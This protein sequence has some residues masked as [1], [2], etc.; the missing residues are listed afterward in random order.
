MGVHNASGVE[1]AL[2]IAVDLGASSG[3]VILGGLAPGELLLQETGRFTH[4]MRKRAGHLRWDLA[5]IVREVKA[6][7]AEAASLARRMNRPIVSIGVDTFGVD[8]AF[9]DKDGAVIDD[10]I[11]YRDSRTA[12]TMAKVFSLVPSQELYGR[13]GIQMMVFNTIFQLYQHLKDGIPENANRLLLMADLINHALCGKVA[14]EYSNATTTQLVD[15]HRRDWDT[16]LIEKIGLPL[17]LFPPI[18]PSG[19]DLG[20]VL[21]ALAE[22]LHLPSDVRVVAPATHDTGSAI[23][24]APLQPGWAYISSGTWSLIGIERTSP[25]I[26]PE[27]AMENFTNEGGAYGTI[28]FLKNCMGLWLFEACKVKWEQEGL[29]VDYGA[30][31]PQVAALTES[32]GLIFPDDPRLFNPDDM[33][34]AIAEQ[35]RETGQT[36]LND[37]VAITKV[38]LDSLALRYARIVQ[39]IEQLTG[40][41]ISGIQVVGG[42]AQNEYLSRATADATGKQVVCGPIEATATGNILVQAI[43]AGR[44][45][46]LATARQHVNANTAIQSYAPGNPERWEMLRQRYAQLESRFVR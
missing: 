37:P 39:T 10:P 24:G 8:Y 28:R 17:K 11:S 5:R 15:S 3:R 23:A 43:A 21:P 33:V 22:E 46:D 34:A 42:G 38:I 41:T 18:V 30:F 27:V 4:P 44:F 40:D 36:P 13:T 20:P 6:G 25:L 9:L 35:M 2:Y 31:L 29:W 26:N 32:P 1:N 14:I 7:I 19:S 16:D 12:D 45:A